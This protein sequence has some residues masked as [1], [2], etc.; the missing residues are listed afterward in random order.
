MDKLKQIPGFLPDDY[1]QEP[2]GIEEMKLD[3]TQEYWLHHY[4]KAEEDGIALGERMA[5]DYNSYLVLGYI[6]ERLN[7]GKIE[8]HELVCGACHIDEDDY[9]AIYEIARQLGYFASKYPALSKILHKAIS[10]E[11]SLIDEEYN[12]EPPEHK[13]LPRDERFHLN[14]YN[15][16]LSDEFEKV[17]D[18]FLEASGDHKLRRDMR[19]KMVLTAIADQLR[20]NEPVQMDFFCNF[21]LGEHS[22]GDNVSGIDVELRPYPCSWDEADTSRSRFIEL[23]KDYNVPCHM[24]WLE[25]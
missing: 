9:D 24:S 20:D 25:D 14:R 15:R 1:D 2:P 3:A 16:I 13:Y 6:K 8:E 5:A 23:C 22:D 11:R 10:W 4:Q 18:Q 19:V 17:Q 12:P 7:R 21:V